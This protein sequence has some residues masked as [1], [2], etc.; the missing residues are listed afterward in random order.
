T[1]A[2]RLR[3]RG[4]IP[5]R[6]TRVV[7]NERVCE[8]CGDCGVKSNCLSVFPVQTPLGTKRR[9]DQSSCNKDYTCVDGDCPSFVTVVAEPSAATRDAHEPPALPEPQRPAIPDDGSYDVYCVGIG[10]TGVVTVNQTLATA[11][12]ADGLMAG[13]VDQTGLSQKAGTVSSHLRLAR[14]R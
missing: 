5:D 4:R 14:S 8:G 12:M 13:G 7:I 3:K 11:A 2:R 6:T 9:I 10:G 1:E